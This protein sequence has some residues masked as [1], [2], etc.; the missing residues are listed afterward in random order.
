MDGVAGR[1]TALAIAGASL[2]L[3]IW[4][5]REDVPILRDTV[6]M[7]TGSSGPSTEGTGNPELDACLAKRVGDVDK[8]R[9]D[10]VVSDAQ[11][12]TFRARAVGFCEA[13]FPPE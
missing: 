7:I 12:E 1:V 3:M 11:Y 13:Q 10:G 9:A 2:G 6:A 8:M 4:I 5:G